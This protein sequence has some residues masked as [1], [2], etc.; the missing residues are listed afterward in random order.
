MPPGPPGACL[1]E[2]P[3]TFRDM[4][5]AAVR[6]EWPV[7]VVVALC[8][9]GIGLACSTPIVAPWWAGEAHLP[10]ALRSEATEQ[11]ADT[12][13]FF[14]SLLAMIAAVFAMLMSS[15]GPPDSAGSEPSARV[16]AGC[17]VLAVAIHF[18]GLVLG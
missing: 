1:F 2:I 18:S 12:I 17:V 8:V 6:D 11:V 13:R 10:A 15:D 4:L 3:M 5:P 16:A 7:L 9:I 14:A